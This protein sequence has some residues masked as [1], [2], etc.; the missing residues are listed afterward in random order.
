MLSKCMAWEA[1]TSTALPIVNYHNN[2]SIVNLALQYEHVKPKM[3]GMVTENYI[4]L[5]I[6]ISFNEK[7]FMKWKVE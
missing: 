3:A 2:R 4:R 1:F 5:N 6:G 7:W